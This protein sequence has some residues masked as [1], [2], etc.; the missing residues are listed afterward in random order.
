MKILNAPI[1]QNRFRLRN[2]VKQAVSKESLPADALSTFDQ[3]KGDALADIVMNARKQ[4]R[5]DVDAGRSALTRGGLKIGFGLTLGIGLGVAALTLTGPLC[6]AVGALSLA[7]SLTAFEGVAEARSGAD[8]ENQGALLDR[9]SDYLL[10]AGP[11][12]N[13]VTLMMHESSFG[14]E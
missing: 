5:S 2:I 1:H 12:D 13:P 10:A 11:S 9:M 7:S 8:Q 6:L 4:S 14:L 3:L